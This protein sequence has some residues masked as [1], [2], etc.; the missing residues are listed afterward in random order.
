MRRMDDTAAS[1]DRLSSR[2]G[3]LGAS[4]LLGLGLAMSPALA[5]APRP[6]ERFPVL[7]KQVQANGASFQVIEQGQGP[8]VLFCHGFPD[9]AETWRSQ[10]RAVAQAGFRAVALDMR[11]YGGSYAPADV[12]LYTALHTVG[13]LVGLRFAALAA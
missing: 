5:A 4:A 11:G 13:D 8:A 10:M 9:T 1:S 3:L 6:D 7:R 12:S 2:R